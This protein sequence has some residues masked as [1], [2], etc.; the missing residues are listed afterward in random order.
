MKTKNILILGS[1]GQIGG[2]LVDFF[3]NKKEYKVERFDLILG[4][5]FD[6]R[7]FKNKNIEKK[8]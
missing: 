8:N 2:H 6:L 1:E 4:K 5:S 3:N 7:N